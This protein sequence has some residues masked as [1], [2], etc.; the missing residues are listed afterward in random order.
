MSDLLN[1]Q[2]NAERNQ[3]LVERNTM[4]TLNCHTYV[5]FLLF[6]GNND[7]HIGR[8]AYR[9]YLNKPQPVSDPYAVQKAIDN[10]RQQAATSILNRVYEEIDNRFE[11]A[12]TEIFEQFVNSDKKELAEKYG[13]S[14]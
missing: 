9:E 6:T 2:P 12:K 14:V 5:S 3:D 8:Q 4:W 11:V 1:G 7:N 13:F 10:V